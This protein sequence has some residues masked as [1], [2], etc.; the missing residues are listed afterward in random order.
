MLLNRLKHKIVKRFMK[1]MVTLAQS[2][3][4][5]RPLNLFDHFEVRSALE[6]EYRE[7]GN[8]TLKNSFRE[9]K[10]QNEQIRKIKIEEYA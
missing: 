5:T 3:Q 4:Y 1:Y 2:E 8:Y 10:Q 6:H 9:F 7:M